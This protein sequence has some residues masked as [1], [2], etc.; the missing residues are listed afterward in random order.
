MGKVL[1][2]V[3]LI[4]VLTPIVGHVY[5]QY[6]QQQLYD[7]YL[8]SLTKVE[9]PAVVTNAQAELEDGQ[10][11]SKPK[12]KEGEEPKK[13]M[14]NEGEVIGKITISKADIDLILLEGTSDKELKIGAGHMHDTANPGDVGN[15][16]IAGHRNYTFGSMFNRLDEIEVGDKVDIEFQ[17]QHYTYCIESVSIV[18][19]DEVSVL[20]QNTK[21]KELT[22]ITCHP[23]YT[24]THRLIIKGK[25]E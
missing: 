10:P 12:E 22:L 14:I 7:D 23:V 21:E 1:I 9:Q 13:L 17:G 5:L 11:A 8:K 3:G 24:G 25:L 19:P 4:F 18:K 15:C 20:A 16:V 2:L 6:K